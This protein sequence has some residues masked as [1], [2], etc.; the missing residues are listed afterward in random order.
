M[1]ILVVGAGSTG[2]YFGGRL[3]Q[4]G[5][6]V[7]FLVHPLRAEV[8]RNI[9]LQILSPHG[10]VSLTP[11]VITAREIQSAFD[12]ILLTVKSFSLHEAIEDF[13]PA[14][15]GS[16]MILPFLNGMKHVEILKARFGGTSV[17]GGVCKIAACID[18]E[19]RIVQL[20]PL[21]ELAYGE[22]DGEV[23]P[24]MAQLDS[25]MHGG[26]FDA[27]LS[28]EIAREMWEKWVLLA[29]LGGVT[30]LMRGSIGQIV[31]APGGTDFTIALLDEVVGLIKQL[32]CELTQSF[33]DS[34]KAM[35]TQEGSQMTSSMFRDLE[36]GKHIEKEQIIGDL[37]TRAQRIGFSTPLMRLVLANLSVYEAKI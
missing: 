32:G 7:T 20:S 34:S 3:M 2:G 37:V 19:G 6:D 12:I 16:S 8:I 13:A 27:R 26:G 17:I 25:V 14:V 21:Q 29:T 28:T 31:A 9:G 35:L 24:R 23:T 10:N 33:I 5:R 15:S 11:I 1:R 4:A 30:C 22:M 36:Q 18:R